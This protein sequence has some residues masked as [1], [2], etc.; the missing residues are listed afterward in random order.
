MKIPS[1]LAKPFSQAPDHEIDSPCSKGFNNFIWQEVLGSF[2][3]TK[4]ANAIPWKINIENKTAKTFKYFMAY[5]HLLFF[6]F[7]QNKILISM[8]RS[9]F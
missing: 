3:V 7:Y 8:K 5:P 1:P 6:T 9:I 4:S 2:T